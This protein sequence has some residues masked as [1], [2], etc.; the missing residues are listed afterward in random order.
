MS[1]T[2]MFFAAVG[3]ALGLWAGQGLPHLFPELLGAFGPFLLAL[4]FALG[5][6]LL[7]EN[8]LGGSPLLMGFGFMGMVG[9]IEPGLP[10]FA[11][12]IICVIF[13]IVVY[14]FTDE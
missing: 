12:W 2:K 13:T 5:F 10:W 14:K 1:Y 11:Y 3:F 8:G 9:L 4:G 7:E 6:F